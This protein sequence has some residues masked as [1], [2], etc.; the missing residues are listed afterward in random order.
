M[1]PQLAR[2]A[3]GRYTKDGATQK[4][5]SSRGAYL[6]LFAIAKPRSCH[7][8]CSQQCQ[9]HVSSVHLI[10]TAWTALQHAQQHLDTPSNVQNPE[11]PLRSPRSF[12][13]W[14][15]KGFGMGRRG[16][17]GV[18]VECAI[19]RICKLVVKVQP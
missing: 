16:G 17:S 2:A 6:V 8:S 19:Y 9:Q 14:E 11:Q 1:A 3:F 4:M 5:T 15:R 12:L 13:G 10:S 18:E 7:I